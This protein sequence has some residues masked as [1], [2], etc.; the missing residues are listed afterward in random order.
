MSYDIHEYAQCTNWLFAAKYI[1]LC[2]VG[3]QLKAELQER[4]RKGKDSNGTKC[5]PPPSKVA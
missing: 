4:T 5:T 2:S 3:S 1:S